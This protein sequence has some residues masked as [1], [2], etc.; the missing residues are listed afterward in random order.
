M[1]SGRNGMSPNNAGSAP[2]IVRGEKAS[3]GEGFA[4]NMRREKD[5]GKSNKRAEGMA[6]GEAHLGMRRK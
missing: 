2:K 5:M 3:T 1:N 6:Y 4:Q